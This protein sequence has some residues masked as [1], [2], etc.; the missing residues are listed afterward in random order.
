MKKLINYSIILL[1]IISISSCYRVKPNADEESVIIAKPFLFGHGGVDNTPVES[2]A[3]WVAATTDHVEFKIVPVNIAEDFENVMTKDNTPVGIT[4]N[5]TLQIQKGKSPQ[6]YQKF[7]QAWYDNSISPLFRTNVRNEF[8][9][10]ELFDLTSKRQTSVAIQ[11]YLNSFLEKRIKDLNIPVKV[12]QIAIAGIVPPD[13]VLDE[14]KKTAAHNQEIY[15][16]TQRALAE[17]SRKQAEINKAIADKAYQN[18]MNMTTQEY[19]SLRH[20]EIEKEKVE[21]IK[22]NK[23]ISIIFGNANPVLP[24]K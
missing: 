21:L 15:S 18:Q 20:L 7:G 17:S 6:L 23:N 9:K 5:V 19:L 12:I 1:T 3:T 4:V 13:A 24:I 22:N 16:Q 11:T 10:Y 8:S 2:G 14:T